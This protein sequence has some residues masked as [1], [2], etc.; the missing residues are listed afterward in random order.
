MLAE[1]KARKPDDAAPTVGYD[2]TLR[3]ILFIAEH[4]DAPLLDQRRHDAEALRARFT[5]RHWPCYRPRL[6]RRRRTR[7]DYQEFLEL[8]PALRDILDK[9]EIGHLTAP[10]ITTQGVELF[11]LCDKKATQSETPEKP[12]RG[13][14]SSANSSRPRPRTFSAICGARP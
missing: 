7:A 14:R 6:A 9:T 1:I 4:G 13:T 2:Y 10:E 12:K 11:A 8:L 5:V 3:P